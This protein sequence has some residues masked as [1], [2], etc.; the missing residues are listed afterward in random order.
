MTSIWL[1]N[2]TI[3]TISPKNILSLWIDLSRCLTCLGATGIKA[4][5][6]VEQWWHVYHMPL[7]LI[8]GVWIHA[9]SLLEEC[10]MVDL[11]LLCLLFVPTPAVRQMNIRGRRYVWLKVRSSSLFFFIRFV[12]FS[13]LIGFLSTIPC[14]DES[15]WRW[16]GITV[17]PLGCW[18]CGRLLL[19]RGYWWLVSFGMEESG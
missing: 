13:F 2:F 3:L 6:V 14:Y 16:C 18:L 7:P 5:G 9:S 1:Q 17:A 15:L 11:V 19:D 4:E 8:A 10:G 12:I